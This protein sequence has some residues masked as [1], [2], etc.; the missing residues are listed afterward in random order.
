VSDERSRRR[1]PAPSALAKRVG[2]SATGQLAPQVAQL[3]LT[4]FILH[5]LGLDRYGVWALA[6]V[7]VTFVS[8]LDGGIG[9]SLSWFFAVHKERGDE[10]AAARLAA[11]TTVVFALLGALLTL[12]LTIGL[13]SLL[14]V[15]HIPVRLWSEAL[16]VRGLVGGLFALGLLSSVP[17]SVLS[18]H[19]R[20]DLLGVISLVRVAVNAALTLALVPGPAGLHGLFVAGVA[21]QLL[22]FLAMTAASARMLS[23]RGIGPMAR[24]EVSMLGS[25]ALRMQG[26]SLARLAN[27]ELDAVVISALLPV[28]MVGIYSIGENAAGAVRMLP[29]YALGPIFTRMA[30]RFGV[31]GRDGAVDEYRSLNRAW[32]TMVTGYVAIGMATLAFGVRSW[33]GPEYVTAGY[34][35]V[36]VFFGYGVNL[37]TGVGTTLARAVGK[38]GLETRYGAWTTVVNLLLTVPLGLLFGI[39]GII[40]ATA[41]ASVTGSIYFTRI[42]RG[43]VGGEFEPPLA[44]IRP[45]AMLLAAAGALLGE[46]LLLRVEVFGPDG[47]LLAG[48]PALLA[49]VAFTAGVRGSGEVRRV[50]SAPPG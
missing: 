33:L 49:F 48:A 45:V 38:P 31:H 2:W 34:V 1:L 6:G 50:I 19:D 8:N 21:A 12:A 18:A 46:V 37:I 47:L 24:E 3:A 5:R 40:G 32:I 17:A 35:A 43:G 11:T 42:L 25:Y 39:W 10:E 23:L 16:S 41:I 29:V 4:P 14:E 9:A 36:V 13:P 30:R 27:V 15:S 22:G 26:S 44:G 7:A 28:R 20:F